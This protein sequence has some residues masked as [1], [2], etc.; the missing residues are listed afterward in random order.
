MKN[1]VNTLERNKKKHLTSDIIKVAVTGAAGSIG[2]SLLF[3]IASGELFGKKQRVE[4]RAIELP[5][6]M[7][8]LKGVAMELDDCAFPLLERVI[9][10]D[11]PECGF[12]SVDSALLV[13]SKPR[14]PGQE[15]GD[16]LKENGKIFQPIG[17]AL[18]KWAQNDVKVTVIGNPCNTNCLIASNNAPDLPVENFTAMTRLDHD[19]GLG[20]LAK[21]S[22]SSIKDISDFCIWGNHSPSMYPDISRC[23][24]NGKPVL[25]VLKKRNCEENVLEW[26]QNEFIPTIQQRGAAII[27]ARGASSAASAA[28]AALMH[29]R[30]W[31][32]GTNENYTSKAVVS[33]GEYGISPGLFFSFPVKCKSSKWKIV[34]NLVLDDFSQK[35][36]QITQK[37]LIE[38]RDAVHDCLPY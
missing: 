24:I 20:Q 35:K 31:K 29:A 32:L 7:N 5:F 28:N 6:A 3:R 13:G 21:K 4:I 30:D 19:R 26:Y 22:G 37:E 8:A 34:E 1:L 17:Q 38:E 18:N 11:D 33:K 25:D 10:T 14:G 9:V 27:Q 15:R 2:Y 16:L 12:D 23:L 36:I